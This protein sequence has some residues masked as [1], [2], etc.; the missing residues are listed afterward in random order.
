MNLN[1]I[2]RERC[3]KLL[4]LAKDLLEPDPVL[5]KRYVSLARKIA[6]RH[7]FSLGSKD[8]CKKCGVVWVSGTTYKT[9]VSSSQRRVLYTC[10]SCNH[11]ASF[12]FMREKAERLLRRKERSS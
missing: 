12:P 11:P 6:M 3:R 5:S 10:L 7:R 8:F 4:S 1:A 2:A 9:R